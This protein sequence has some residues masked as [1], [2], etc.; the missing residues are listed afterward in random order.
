MSTTPLQPT[1]P[2]IPPADET[3]LAAVPPVESGDA[4]SDIIDLPSG[5]ELNEVSAISLATSRPIRWVVVAGP[6]GS[7]KTTLLT[8]L[9]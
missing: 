4:A 3:A 9:Y 8:S 6:V 7:G 2:V 5:K 1:P